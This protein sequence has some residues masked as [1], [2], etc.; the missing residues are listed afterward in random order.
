MME[1]MMF[2]MT[3]ASAIAEALEHEKQAARY[4]RL[5]EQHAMSARCM[6]AQAAYQRE[7]ALIAAHEYA[8]AQGQE[9]T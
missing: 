4:R 7:A 2:Q 9:Q 5:A 6:R 8:L 3:G 1:K